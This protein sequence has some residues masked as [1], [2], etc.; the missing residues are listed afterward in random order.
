MDNCL[1]VNIACGDTYIEGWNNF[2]YEPVSTAVKRA[3]LLKHIPVSDGEAD[4]VYSSHFFEHIP[5]GGVNEFLAECFRVTKPGGQIRLVMPDLE[6]LCRSYL[7]HRDAGQHV[8]AGFLILEMLDQCVRSVSGGELGAFYK[9]LQSS[10]LTD[11]GMIEFVKYYTGHVILPPSLTSGSRLKRV[12]NN[13]V[14]L[15]KKLENIYIKAVLLMLPSAFRQ[16]NVSLA[17]VGERHTWIYDFYTVQQ[18]LQQA[19][20]ADVRRLSASTSS[21]P[22]FPFYPLDVDSAG[23]PRKGAESMYIEALKP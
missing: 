22:D 16:Q 18:L 5:F 10:S 1:C 6:N 9:R 15:L 13:P 17:L 2:D 14:N 19:G 7:K 11:D 21:V 4:I 3:N 20:F 8:E 12:L 23:R